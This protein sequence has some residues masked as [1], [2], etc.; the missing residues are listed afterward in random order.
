MREIANDK[1]VSECTKFY[2]VQD[3]HLF[4]ALPLVIHPVSLLEKRQPWGGSDA[5]RELVEDPILLRQ[6]IRS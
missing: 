6:T 1:L 5:H 2:F 3:Q 4:C